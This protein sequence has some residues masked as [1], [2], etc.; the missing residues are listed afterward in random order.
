M[1]NTDDCWQLTENVSFTAR[2]E[3][4]YIVVDP[5]I[6]LHSA[7]TDAVIEDLPALFLLSQSEVF[8]LDREL[9]DRSHQIDVTT[10]QHRDRAIA[11]ILH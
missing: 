3:E 2:H 8:V 5:K 11:C 4:V 10:Q 7:I 9:S 6:C 1:R